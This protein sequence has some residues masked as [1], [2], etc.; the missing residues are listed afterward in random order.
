MIYR[1]NTCRNSE[2]AFRIPTLHAWLPASH[3]RAG[4]GKN[5]QASEN[6][7]AA[8]RAR[9]SASQQIDSSQNLD[10]KIADFV[11]SKNGFTDSK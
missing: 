8:R 9:G 1:S 10:T 11:H 6:A 7:M 3:L 2:N 5:V 4:C